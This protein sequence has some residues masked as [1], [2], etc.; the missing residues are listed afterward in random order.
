MDPGSRVDYDW[1]VVLVKLV[2][3]SHLLLFILIFELAHV[4]KVTYFLKTLDHIAPN[5]VVVARYLLIIRLARPYL[6]QVFKPENLPALL[7]PLLGVVVFKNVNVAA[8]TKS[9][10]QELRAVNANNVPV[11][12]HFIGLLFVLGRWH[13]H[14][15]V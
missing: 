2:L 6:L 15:A 7:H 1:S 13:W 8:M 5:L 4:L 9:F 14:L 12:A 10:Q 11:A 3:A